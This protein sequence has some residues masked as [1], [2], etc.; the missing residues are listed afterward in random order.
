MSKYIYVANNLN[1]SQMLARFAKEGVKGR[2]G[3]NYHSGHGAL[4]HPCTQPLQAAIAHQLLAPFIDNLL[5]QEI[6]KIFLPT[7]PTHI[8]AVFH[9][10]CNSVAQQAISFL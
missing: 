3:I 4:S 8:H 9:L 6:T 1:N 2:V 5:L 10:H 7:H